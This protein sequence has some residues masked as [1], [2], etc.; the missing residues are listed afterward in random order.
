VAKKIRAE[1]HVVRLGR[2]LAPGGLSALVVVLVACAVALPAGAGS[3]TTAPDTPYMVPVSITD[4]GITIHDKFTKGATTRYPR[5][6]IIEFV[7]TNKGTAPHAVRLALLT[8][9]A[10]T[11]YEQK[12]TN[13]SA[14]SPIAPGK[15]RK[16]SINFYYRGSFALEVLS[17]SK[18][19]ASAQIVVY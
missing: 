4:K 13:I 18:P 15:R 12:I 5:S 2:R 19:R 17:G 1:G 11:K 7:I 8:K 14:G 16:F 10:F 9:H 6:A 3:K